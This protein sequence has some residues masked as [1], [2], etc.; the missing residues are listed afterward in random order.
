MLRSESTVHGILSGRKR[1]F[2]ASLARALLWPT[3]LVYREA[4]AIRNRLYDRKLRRIHRADCPVISV[5]NITAG[6]TGKTPLV[7]YIAKYLL[8]R[9]RRVAI[10]S[11]GY[12]NRRRAAND[13]ELMLRE[14]LPDVPHVTGK[15]RVNCARKAIHEH[16][17]DV[18]IMDD[19]F[20]H[21]KLHRDLDIVVIDAT[22]P[23]GYGHV[24]PRGILRESPTSLT[25]A[26]VAVITRTELAEPEE[27]A[28]LDERVKGLAPDIRIVHA[29]TGVVS[30]DDLAG[31][32]AMLF[33]GIGNPEA[34]RRTVVRLGAE[35]AGLFSFGDHH[36]YTENDLKDVNCAAGV[37]KADVILTTQKDHVKMPSRFPWQHE[38]SVVRIE[39]R[40]T[41]GEDVLHDTIDS[42]VAPREDAA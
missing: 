16:N 24:M 26:D 21:R 5:G 41:K 15:N 1:G 25:R 40:I 30:P 13:E 27:L 35:V 18:I 6:G 9:G 31:K 20:Q 33:C 23:F 11:Q 17:A 38:V 3:S 2:W 28:R 29:V 12:G 42:A 32:R 4:M 22:N 34:F 37:E 19:G 14:N 7:E 36:H 8:H 10:V 39:M